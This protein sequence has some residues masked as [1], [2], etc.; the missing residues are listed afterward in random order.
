MF[1]PSQ[2][3]RVERCPV[4]ETYP[5]IQRET[6]FSA[7]GTAAHK[8]M[9][10]VREL[11]A[12]DPALSV[13]Q[14]RAAALRR[15]EDP[16]HLPVLEALPLEDKRLPSLDPSAYTAELA[17]ALDVER[18]S[19]RVLGKGLS[20]EQARALARPG[21]MVGIADLAGHAAGRGVVWDL[22]FGHGEVP[23]AAV[24]RQTDTY[25]LM[26]ALALGLDGGYQGIVRVWGEGAVW[27]D[28]VERDA[29]ELDEHLLRLRALVRQRAEVLALPPAERPRPVEGPWCEHCPAFL[30]CEAKLQLL[31]QVVADP[32]AA[33][34]APPSGPA[35]VVDPATLGE[36]WNRLRRA[37]RALERVEAIYKA[38][39]RAQPIPIGEGKVLGERATE[40]E[41]LVGPAAI[42]ALEAEYGP[43]GKAVAE[44]ARS[45]MTAASLERA[46]KKHLLPTLP[47]TPTNKPPAF[48]PVE[49]DVWARLAK[50][51]ATRPI[52]VRKVVEHT[53]KHRSDT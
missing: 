5:H 34:P 19:A 48:A 45:E 10:D 51:G 15:V 12:A 7:A 17:M 29:L 25:L 32:E 43:V 53:P 8:L 44:E 28:V 26:L 16:E 41:S 27:P 11:R 21:E 33:C 52:I 20:R 23:R 6:A 47:R 14:A 46:L 50:R 49:R 42:R 30:H 24:N 2:V 31:R 22:K 9:A 18:G 4:S 38:I 35:V 40:S 13:E 39:A 3:Y 36:G 1:S 37:Q